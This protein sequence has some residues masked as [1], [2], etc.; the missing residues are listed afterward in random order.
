MEFIINIFINVFSGLILLFL[1]PML[2]YSRFLRRL[3]RIGLYRFCED[4][5]K[6]FKLTKKRFEKKIHH[7]YCLNCAITIKSKI[8]EICEEEARGG[9]GFAGYIECSTCGERCME[10]GFCYLCD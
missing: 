7:Q 1:T 8:D 10:R 2:L 9:M 3:I 4:C 6:W 5:G